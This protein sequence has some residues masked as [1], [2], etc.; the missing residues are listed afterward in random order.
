[1][2]VCSSRCIRSSCHPLGRVAKNHVNL[3]IILVNYLVSVSL[4]LV[5]I[6]FVIPVL[7]IFDV[8]DGLV[9]IVR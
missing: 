1:M 3:K 9:L 5:V 6:P 8:K 4:A 2:A 7:L